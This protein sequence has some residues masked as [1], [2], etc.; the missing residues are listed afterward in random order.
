MKPRESWKITDWLSVITDCVKRTDSWLNSPLK[1]ID[2]LGDLSAIK[3]FWQYDDRVVSRL[4]G[5]KNVPHYYQA[6]SSRQYLNKIAT[7]TLIIQASDDPF[8]TKNTL[9]R[10][11]E[12]SSS[13]TLELTSGGGHVGFVSGKN[14][15]KPRYWLEQRIPE[16][17]RQHGI[18]SILTN[19]TQQWV[20]LIFWTGYL[21]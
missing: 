18:W 13:V 12:L 1:Q 16:F 3:S 7:S 17:F 20:W 14:P 2:Q 11:E 21:L 6:S 9:P 15:F 10:Q 5:F 8:M 19:K 4:H